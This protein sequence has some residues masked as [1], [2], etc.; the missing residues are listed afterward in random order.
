MTSNQATERE[1]Y[2]RKEGDGVCVLGGASFSEKMNEE[3]ESWLDQHLLNAC[4]NVLV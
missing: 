4:M 1:R 3:I 2:R